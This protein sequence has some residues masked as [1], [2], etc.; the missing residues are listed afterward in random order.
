MRDYNLDVRGLSF[1]FSLLLSCFIFDCGQLFSGQD[2]KTK[3]P[4]VGEYIGAA[5]VKSL[6]INLI[7]NAILILLQ[8]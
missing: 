4:D 1:L 3:I 8:T 6:G 5:S 2:I 7:P